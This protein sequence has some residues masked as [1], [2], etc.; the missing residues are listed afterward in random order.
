MLSQ[1]AVADDPAQVAG[2]RGA[3]ADVGLREYISGGIV[4]HRDEDDDLVQI[5][6]LVLL[7]G[8]EREHQVD[9]I[10]EAAR[11]R[12]RA[13]RYN[14]AVYLDLRVSYICWRREC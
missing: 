3:W 5:E 10:C 12:T 6:R 13:G 8:L 7:P 14:E 4:A 9:W 1:D 2:H 11:N